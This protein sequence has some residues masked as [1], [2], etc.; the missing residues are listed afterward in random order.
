MTEGL[1]RVVV[2]A[3]GTITVSL[4]VGAA[5][6]RGDRRLATM[7]QAV[8]VYEMITATRHDRLVAGIDDVSL[9]EEPRDGTEF[10]LRAAQLL[11]EEHEVTDGAALRIRRQVPDT[12]GLGRGA[13]DAAAT[14]VALDRLW[15]LALPGE[16]L[17]RLG[18]RL[19]AEVPFAMLGHTA[20]ARGTGADLTTV[21]THGEWTW[22]LACPSGRLS[23]AEVYRRHDQI[24]LAVGRDLAA[25]PE[26][27]EQQF[28]ALSSGDA[29]LLGRT[30]HSDLQAAAFALL[31]DLES[32]VEAAE[33]A[34]AFG[35]VVSG[36]GPTVAV[37]V[38]DDAQAQ[39]VAALLTSEK[40][41]ETCRV[42]RGSA[43]GV[44]VLEES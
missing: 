26:I 38:E 40:L 15:G 2:R 5:D 22:L 13:A 21:L 8:D 43:P 37:L 3:P 25:R 4:A 32:L 6:G 7:F 39:E 10:A 42:V 18:A 36:V 24:A 31:P 1:D 11:R 33:R 14:L 17:R 16:E 28:Q 12:G 34:G 23:I 30:L 27:D 20:L 35:A 9:R 44:G 19:G 29:S 41:V